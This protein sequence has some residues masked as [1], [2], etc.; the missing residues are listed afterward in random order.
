[1]KQGNF[2]ST[3]PYL[4]SMFTKECSGYDMAPHIIYLK[5][6]EH[7]HLLYS[8]TDHCKLI[9]VSFCIIDQF[10]SSV[11]Y[12]QSIDTLMMKPC[13]KVKN[14]NLVHGDFT[15]V[16][17]TYWGVHSEEK[18][19]KENNNNKNAIYGNFKLLCI[20]FW[21][22][23]RHHEN[24]IPLRACSSASSL[25]THVQLIQNTSSSMEPK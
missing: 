17:V 7:S 13:F 11:I 21:K 20:F 1:M 24:F 10:V 18:K 12:T 14:Q 16:N 25:L 8:S 6:W 5:W 4:D 19:V 3:T 22:D 2:Y 15:E 9:K 23:S